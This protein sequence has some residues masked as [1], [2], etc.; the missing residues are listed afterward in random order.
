MF[1]SARSLQRPINPSPARFP[2]SQLIY[3]PPPEHGHRPSRSP[4]HRPLGLHAIPSPQPP[5]TT[6]PKPTPGK[7]KHPTT[8]TLMPMKQNRKCHCTCVAFLP[9]QAGYGT[10]MPQ[11]PTP[12]QPN[13]PSFFRFLPCS[14]SLPQPPPPESKNTHS[15]TVQQQQPSTSSACWT[16]ASTSCRTRPAA[17]RT[18]H[19]DTPSRGG[20]PR[21]AGP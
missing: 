9:E 7:Q 10:G 2:H 17:G 4:F 19:R 3:P 21:A 18:D 11:P 5:H 15:Q 8:T 20:P 13:Q 6:D 16:R 14:V 1:E 12:H